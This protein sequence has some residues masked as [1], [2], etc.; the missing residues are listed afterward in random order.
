MNWMLL[1]GTG[2]TTG[3]MGQFIGSVQ[4]TLGNWGSIIVSIIGV[5]MV[6]AGVYKVAKNL[7]SHGKGQNSWAVAI[8]LILVGGALAITGGWSTIKTITQTGRE[9]IDKFAAGT[10]D[11]TGTFHDP[12]DGGAGPAGGGGT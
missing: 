1:L 4:E 6:I 3:T 9:T 2:G 10:A 12:F 8:A 11:T 7:I 5:V